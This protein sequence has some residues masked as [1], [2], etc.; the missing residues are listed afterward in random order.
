MPNRWSYATV[1]QECGPLSG[2]W[3]RRDG[4]VFVAPLVACTLA[5]FGAVAAGRPQSNKAV[6]CVT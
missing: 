5:R 1:G 4:S 2:A 6:F 3:H